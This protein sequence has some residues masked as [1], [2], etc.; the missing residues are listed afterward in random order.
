MMISALRFLPVVLIVTCGSLYA[1]SDSVL[2]PHDR[3]VFIGNTFADNL[4]RHNYLETALIARL[5]EHKLTFRNLGWSADTLSLQPRPLNFGSLDEHLSRAR[6]D[7][8]VACFGMNESYD[9]QAGL[10]RFRKQWDQL[11]EHFAAQ[12]YNGESAPRVILVT[13]IAHEQTDLPVDAS[14]HNEQL[15]LYSAAMQAIA[16]TRGLTC[17]DLFTPTH[18]QMQTHPSQKL[19]E[20]GIHLNEYGYWAVSQMILEQL[21]GQFPEW[22]IEIRCDPNHDFSNPLAIRV[23]RPDWPTPA[24]P[25]ETIAS[26]ELMKSQPKLT[27]TGLPSGEYKLT[28]DGKQTAQASGNDWSRGVV[29]ANTPDQQYVE[30]IRAAVA[31]KNQTFFHRWRAPNSEYIFGRRTKPY[32]IVTFPPEMKEFDRLID[33]KEQRVL[34]LSVPRK[35][36]VWKLEQV[37]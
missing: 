36:A 2:E 27:V 24:V 25:P 14:A 28:I 8:I 29:L 16:K 35:P 32:G 13:P 21:T 17:V 1:Q 22:S 6:A 26:P 3:V 19:T 11:L 30:N 4:R 7:V 23:D 5:P 18:Q 34:K 31:G 37:K 10:E 33:E 15:K 12:R 9:G 20:N